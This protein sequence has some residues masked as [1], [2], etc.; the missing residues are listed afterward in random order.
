[1]RRPKAVVTDFRVNSP[2][3]GRGFPLVRE[4]QPQPGAV[5][6][7]KTPWDFMAE[8][9]QRAGTA[10][11]KMVA[12]LPLVIHQA[13]AKDLGSRHCWNRKDP[14]HRWVMDRLAAHGRAIASELSPR[15]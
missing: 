3:A 5:A 12:G 8:N 11:D 13:A 1:M 9:N 4:F 15:R 14:E 7:G 2:G 10:H 6:S